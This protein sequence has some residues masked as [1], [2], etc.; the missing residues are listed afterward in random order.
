MTLEI[1]N[2]A[3][4]HKVIV[5]NSKV[6]ER[7]GGFVDYQDEGISTFMNTKYSSKIY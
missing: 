7:F 5:N 3:S 4:A 2:V 1:V 6:Y